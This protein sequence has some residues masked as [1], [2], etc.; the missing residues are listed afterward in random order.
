MADIGHHPA[1]SPQ[2]ET[3][4]RHYRNQVTMRRLYSVLIVIGVV[5]AL[6]AAMSYANAA[7]SGKFFERLPYMFD[8]VKN[9]VPRDPFEIFRAMF[10][11]ESPYHDGSAKYDYTQGRVYL[12]DWLYIP[13]FIYQLI[14]TVNIAIVSTI[15]GGVLAFCLCFFAATN[16]VG[17][18]AARWFVRRVMEVLRAFPEIVIAGLLTAVLSIGPIAAIVA[19]SLHTI[20]ALGKLFF[21]VV[22]NADMKPD[23]GLKSVGATWL[24]R[25]CFA[26][27][28][29]VLPNFVSY[30]LLRLEI[31]VRASTI[32]GAVGGGGIGEVFRLSIGRDYAAQTYAIIILLLVTIIAIDQLSGWLRRRLVGDQSFNLGKA[33]V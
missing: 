6:G 23:E 31:N 25:V 10:G 7:N 20:G 16:L 17:S 3:L 14:V 21:E 8:F 26:I 2:S 32:I 13:N 5:A 22:E 12:T 18:G 33:S 15:V 4:L 1:L 19:V 11:L 30:G 24:E 29:Q 28:P 27:V 9:F